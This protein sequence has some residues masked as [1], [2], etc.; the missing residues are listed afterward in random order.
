M[1]VRR[2]TLIYKTLNEHYTKH[3]LIQLVLQYHEH[4]ARLLNEDRLKGSMLE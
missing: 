3:E 4:I 1:T 2:D